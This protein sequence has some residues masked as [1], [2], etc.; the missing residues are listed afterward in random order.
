MADIVAR[1]Q[2]RSMKGEPPPV[3]LLGRSQVRNYDV[4]IAPTEG[5]SAGIKIILIR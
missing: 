4:R 3:R 2:H 1:S 5:H